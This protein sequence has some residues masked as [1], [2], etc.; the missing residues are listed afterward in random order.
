MSLFETE[1]L[2]LRSYN[3][4]EAD[5]IV[6]LLTEE[7]GLVR[8]VAKGAKRLKSQFGGSLEPF[9]IVK[10]SIYQKETSELASIRHLELIRSYFGSA[11]NPEFLHQFSY[12]VE[13]LIEFAPPNDPN[14]RLYRMTK[15]CLESASE[16]AGSLEIVGLYFEIWLLKLCG[17]LPDWSHCE[18]CRTEFSRDGRSTL[19]MNFNLRCDKCKQSRADG[20]LT[21]QDREIMLSAQRMGPAKFIRTVENAAS[22]NVSVILRR[23]IAHVLGRE[24]ANGKI[25]KAKG[26]S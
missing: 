8:G 5:K 11:S 3:L 22:K 21:G 20:T 26:Y 6:L 15:V 24:F 12:L 9:T 10:A 1:A 17:F 23:M 16:N 4:S 25:V 7:H 18:V 14:E 13:M 2:I 19:Q